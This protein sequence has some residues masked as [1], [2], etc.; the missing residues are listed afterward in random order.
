MARADEFKLRRRLELKLE[1]KSEA[2]AIVDEAAEAEEVA[3][4]ARFE[5][6]ARVD[7][8]AEAGFT[9]PQ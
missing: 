5:G 8:A 1:L 9:V 7:D 6:C 3:G 4:K 2:E